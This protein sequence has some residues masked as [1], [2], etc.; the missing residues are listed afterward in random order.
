MGADLAGVDAKG[1]WSWL[2]FASM[3]PAKP[4]EFDALSTNKQLYSGR[5][6]VRETTG[7]NNGGVGGTLLLRDGGDASGTIILTQG[8]AASSSFSHSFSAF[9]VLCEIGVFLVPGGQS[10][11]GCVLLVPLWEYNITP[12]GE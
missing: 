3:L 6:I 4:I 10:L 7:L 8:Y 9:G 11:T 1:S 5:C 2:R 12:P